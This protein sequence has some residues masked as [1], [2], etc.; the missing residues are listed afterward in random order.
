MT[1]NVQANQPQFP[2]GPKFRTDI[3]GDIHTPVN[4]IQLGNEDSFDGFVSGTNPMPVGAS[5]VASTNNNS[6][7]PLAGGATF[8]G[9]AEQNAHSDVMVSCFSDT[10]GTLYFDF[11]VDGTNW[12]TFP[13]GGFVV[14]ASIH[15]F[16]TAVKGPRYFRVR[17]VNGASAQATFQLYTYYGQYRQ[18][19]A[20]LN[21]PLGLDSDAILVRPTFPWLDVTRGLVSGMTVIKKFGRGTVGTTFSPLTQTTSY[22]TP[23]S[24]SATALR[25]KA[26]GNAADTLSASGAWEVT[27][28]GLDENFNL[29]SEAVTTNGA[30]ASSPTSATFTRMFRAY[31]SASGTYASA[32]AGSHF[33]AITIENSAGGTDW[34]SIGATNFPKGQSEIAAYS[35][36][37]GYTAYVFLDDVT[38]DSGKTADL[39]FFHRANIDETAAPYTAIR[40][41]SVL[42]GIGAGTTDLSGRNVPFGPF[43]G[44][45]DIGYMGRVSATTGQI[46]AEFEIFLVNE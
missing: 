15:E 28:E 16:H 12:R 32:T 37:T 30:S 10:A 44:P 23:Q 39:I 38:I 8:T 7:T 9:T 35:V 45:C 22:P 41:K 6:V 19:S 18:P 33:A 31:V 5:G 27:L 43:V 1:D 17:F 13:T 3:E 25:I 34:G 42:T 24:G 20:P 36:P 29:V 46:A 4:K 40:A 2:G 14:S 21:Q 26:G 11:S